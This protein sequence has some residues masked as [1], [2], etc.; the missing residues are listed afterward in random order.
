MKVKISHDGRHRALYSK[1]DFLAFIIRCWGYLRIVAFWQNSEERIIE[2]VRFGL[3][4]L[5]PSFYS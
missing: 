4:L 1:S 5:F 3:V 2:T